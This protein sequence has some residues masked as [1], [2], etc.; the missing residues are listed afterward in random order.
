MRIIYCRISYLTHPKSASGLPP[1]LCKE[2]GRVPGI[3]DEGV[4]QNKGD[5]S[6][7]TLFHS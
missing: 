7:T 6:N 2:R 4:S 1:S 5:K 3:R